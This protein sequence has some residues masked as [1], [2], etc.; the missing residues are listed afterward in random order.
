[1]FGIAHSYNKFN[2]HIGK[3]TKRYKSKIIEH[4]NTGRDNLI[5]SIVPGLVK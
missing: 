1:M 3:L 2:S 4:V 5:T